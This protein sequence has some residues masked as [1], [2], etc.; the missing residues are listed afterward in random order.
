MANWR[1]SIMHSTPACCSPTWRCA[2]AMPWASTAAR[3]CFVAPAKGQ[4]QLPRLLNNV[5][6]LETTLQPVDFHAVA[7]D[8]L[9]RQKRRALL[10]LLSNLRDD[11]GE[12][13]EAVQRLSRQHR[14]LVVSL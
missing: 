9:A 11:D 7:S 14:V 5:Y 3:P 10:V 4:Q 6:D 2:R 12:L 1:I 8:V 13:L